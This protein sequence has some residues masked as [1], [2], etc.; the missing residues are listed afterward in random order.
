MYSYCSSQIY[1]HEGTCFASYSLE[2]TVIR[3][4]MVCL[5]HTV[6]S[7]FLQLLF[8]RVSTVWTNQS[9]ELKKNGADHHSFIISGVD[10]TK[11]WCLLHCSTCCLYLM[12]FSYAVIYVHTPPGQPHDH[13]HHLRLSVRKKMDTKDYTK[14]TKTRCEQDKKGHGRQRKADL[15]ITLFNNKLFILWMILYHHC[16][17]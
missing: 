15:A 11:D 14:A 5:G 9:T 6:F 3:I 16:I 12:L 13:D 2:N 1:Q 10:V 4:S 17:L 8:A 7:E